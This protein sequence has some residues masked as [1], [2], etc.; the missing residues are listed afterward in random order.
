MVMH[1]ALVGPLTVTCHVVVYLNKRQVK[2]ETTTGAGKDHI[3]A[4]K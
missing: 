3:R 2:L 4:C 1:P